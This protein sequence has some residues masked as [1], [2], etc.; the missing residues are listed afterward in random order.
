MGT[1][2]PL[3]LC[4]ASSASRHTVEDP[5]MSVQLAPTPLLPVSFRS[6]IRSFPRPRLWPQ[7][8]PSTPGSKGQASALQVVL[9]GLHYSSW[10][11]KFLHPTPTL[12]V[13]CRERRVSPG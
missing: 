12:W 4:Y 6:Q 2:P 8:A 11:A 9:F 7:S 5:L 13:Q 3:P 1:S 10:E